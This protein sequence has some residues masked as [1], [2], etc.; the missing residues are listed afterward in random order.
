VSAAVVSLVLCPHLTTV[1][2]NIE[3]EIGLMIHSSIIRRSASHLGNGNCFAILFWR[4]GEVQLLWAYC[5]FVK[6]LLEKRNENQNLLAFL[7]YSKSFTL[8]L[9]Q[10]KNTP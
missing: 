1:A 4:R 5:I 8:K 10:P 6:V 2:L 9:V 7:R 3:D